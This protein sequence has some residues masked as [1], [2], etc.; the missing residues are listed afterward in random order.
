MK[1]ILNTVVVVAIAL[2]GNAYADTLQVFN[3]G[4]GVNTAS[5][6]DLQGHNF[7]VVGKVGLTDNIYMSSTDARIYF[8]SYFTFAQGNDTT[9]QVAFYLGPDGT[10][11]S[12]VFKNSLWVE[13]TV[14][15]RT[16]VQHSDV[17]VKKNIGELTGD[18]ELKRVLQLRPVSFEYTDSPDAMR[19]RGFIAQD[20]EKIYPELVKEVENPSTGEQIKVLAVTEL[21]APLLKAVQKQQAM[22]DELQK[23]VAQLEKK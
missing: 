3:S 20:V 21:L 14:Y 2:A 18:D 12:G 4:V 1:R 23:R 11:P 15:Y 17:K 22:I 9:N 7:Q 8:P 13:N 16:L 10:I 19:H 5:S 6:T